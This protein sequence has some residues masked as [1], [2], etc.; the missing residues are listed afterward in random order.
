MNSLYYECHITTDVIPPDKR[1]LFDRLCKNA[2]FWASDW[3]LADTS[4]KFFATSRG[5]DYTELKSRMCNLILDLKAFDFKV[6]RYKIEDT[7]LDSKI[8]D[9]YNIVDLKSS[10]ILEDFDKVSEQ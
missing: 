10:E 4:L 2:G 7:I 6:W 1:E 9:I 5:H 3:K 8:E